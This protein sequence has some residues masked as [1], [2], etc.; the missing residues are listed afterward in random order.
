MSSLA[1]AVHSV[2]IYENSSAFLSR[3]CGIVYSGLQKGNSVL[4]VATEKHRDE[5]VREL[6]GTGV[7]VRSR[8]REGRYTMVDAQELLATFMVGGM[9][10]RKRFEAS[11]GG[12]LE[13]VRNIARR[14]RRQVTVFG[15]MVA[16]LWEN[17]Q[18]EAALRLE[19]LWNEMLS[20][21]SFHLHCAYPKHILDGEADAAAV[22]GSHS[23]VIT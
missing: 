11:V 20:R 17:G 12:M 16:V 8:A 22:C 7:D 9:P 10:D 13:V 23:H 5:L 1:P 15:E 18:R 3:L 19:E 2:Q 4:I 6:R 21:H 14:K